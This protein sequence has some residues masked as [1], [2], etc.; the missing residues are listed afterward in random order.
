MS[1]CL[2]IVF[3]FMGL[4]IPFWPISLPIC[5]GFA[6]ILLCAEENKK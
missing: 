1:G 6:A 3:F 2:S 4:I 5:W